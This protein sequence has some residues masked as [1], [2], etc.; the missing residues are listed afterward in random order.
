[1][2][3]NANGSAELVRVPQAGEVAQQGFSSGQLEVRGETATSTLAAQARA[4]VEARFV[5]ALRRPRD[6]DQVRV[7]LLAA[8]SRRGFAEAAWYSK[9][10]G[11]QYNE[12]TGKWEDKYAEGLSIR[13]AEEAA[14]VM[15]N[16]MPETYAIY[17]DPRKRIVRIATTDLE[18]NL[19]YVKDITV[20]K[21]VERRSL[22]KGQQALG[23]RYNSY[24]EKVYIVV[25]SD[26][27]MNKKESAIISKVMRDQINRMVPSDIKEECQRKIFETMENAASQDPAAE[28]KKV[29]DAF[30]AVGIEPKHLKEYLGHDLDTLSPPE[31]VKLRGIYSAIKE[32]ETTWSSIM[33]QKNEGDGGGKPVDGDKPKEP[34]K[35]EE[36]PAEPQAK[37]KT[38]LAD[39][40]AKSKAKREGAQQQ[41]ELPTPGDKGGEPGG[42]G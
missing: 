36:K 41:P 19:I 17:D 5:M 18:S 11:K 7:K 30:A 26:D 4:A 34:P 9:P 37:S 6:I 25:A 15:G 23:E 28:K 38:S 21:S 20:E 13:F 14:R 40:A 39:A 12:E 3:Q 8:C 32:G 29:M 42:D 33:E 1:M 35:A 24:G 31:I 10:V 27:D 16:L 2:T 22:R